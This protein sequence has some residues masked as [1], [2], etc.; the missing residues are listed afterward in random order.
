MDA[1]GGSHDRTALHY[2]S[3]ADHVGVAKI[4][5]ENNANLKVKDKNGYTAINLTKGGEM[6]QLLHQVFVPHICVTILGLSDTAILVSRSIL[7]PL[8]TI[9]NSSRYL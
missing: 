6:C 4:L 9:L 5:K 8:F 7:K 3:V 1:V 2:A